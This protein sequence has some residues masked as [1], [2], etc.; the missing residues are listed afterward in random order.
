M[1]TDLQLDAT[2]NMVLCLCPYFLQMKAKSATLAGK[3]P[4]DNSSLAPRERSRPWVGLFTSAHLQEPHSSMAHAE[5]CRSRVLVR[6]EMKYVI[7]VVVKQADA[8]TRSL[9]LPATAKVARSAQSPPDQ[10]R[11]S[12]AKRG[13]LRV[14][15]SRSEW[16][17]C[18]ARTDHSLPQVREGGGAGGGRLKEGFKSNCNRRYSRYQQLFGNKVWRF[19]NGWYP[20]AGGKKRLGGNDLTSR[21]PPSQAHASWRGWGVGGLHAH[22]VFAAAPSFAT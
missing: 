5:Q 4:A 19:Q 2:Y 13:G 22:G 10:V 3:A 6:G 7:W 12:R 9:A 20:V 1:P 8:C 21:G 11:P 17:T 16:T 18:R 14:D 15:P